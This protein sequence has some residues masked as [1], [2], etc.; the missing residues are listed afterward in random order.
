MHGLWPVCPRVPVVAVNEHNCGLDRR[1]ATYIRYAQAVP[2]V[3]S[4]DPN[5]CIGCGLCEKV[6]LAEAVCYDDAPRRSEIEVGP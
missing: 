1:A 2:L 5:T 3:F 4:I 6:C